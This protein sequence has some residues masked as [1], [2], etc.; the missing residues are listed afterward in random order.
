MS[1]LRTLAYTQCV[2]KL[3]IKSEK[4]FTEKSKVLSL[5]NTRM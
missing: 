1:M 5:R 3:V 2:K 4:K